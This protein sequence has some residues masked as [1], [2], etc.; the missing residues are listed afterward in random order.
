LSV[1]R[2]L[3]YIGIT[4]VRFMIRSFFIS[5]L[6]S[7]LHLHPYHPF[8]PRIGRPRAVIT[9]K[10]TVPHCTLAS[11]IGLALRHAA[12]SALPE[13]DPPLRVE[14]RLSEGSHAQEADLSKQVN[15]KERACAAMEVP[16]IQEMIDDL[17]NSKR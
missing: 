11:T 10:P 7:I 14:I 6:S 1:K 2:L 15:D 4:N 5:Y 17:V 13:L 3:K 12:D 9:F 16:R 8:L